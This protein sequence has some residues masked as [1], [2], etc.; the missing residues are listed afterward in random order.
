MPDHEIVWLPSF[1]MDELRSLALHLPFCY[2]NLRRSI[3]DQVLATDATPSSGGAVLASAPPALAEELWR[4]SE[5]RGEALRL[6]RGS[7]FLE[8]AGEPKAPSVFASVAAECM[9][10]KPVH[11][12]AITMSATA[13]VR[14][15]TLWTSG[16]AETR[17]KLNGAWPAHQPHQILRPNG[18]P[19][20]CE[21]HPRVAIENRLWRHAVHLANLA[22]ENG[23]PFFL[24][25][26]LCSKAWQFREI[27]LLREKAGVSRHVLHMCAYSDVSIG[28]LPYKKPTCI[29]TSAPWFGAVVKTCPGCF[30]H[31]EPP[32]RAC[33]KQTGVYPRAFCDS[34]ASAFVKWC[35]DRAS[36]ERRPHT[37]LLTQPAGCS[38]LASLLVR[39][40]RTAD[41]SSIL[42]SRHRPCTHE[43]H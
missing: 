17:L 10:W 22:Y 36:P 37:G 1:V 38:S 25:H 21:L 18:W 9:E 3:A 28:E 23:I 35:D 24:E 27:E 5:H 20:G 31:G 13:A 39:S 15:W 41:Y 42:G 16:T 43:G 4:L 34:I 30:S 2:T 33:A 32:R 40:A 26:P 6:D 14:C 29:L 11:A 8:D 19:E 12:S 7:A